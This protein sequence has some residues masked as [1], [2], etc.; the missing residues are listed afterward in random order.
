M[1]RTLKQKVVAAGQQ[2]PVSGTGG[3]AAGEA[4]AR[5]VAMILLWA[6]MGL[7]V[8]RVSV[9]GGLSPFGVGLAAAAAGPGSLLVYIAVSVGYLLSSGTLFP[10]RYI[11]AV[12]AV[13]GIRWSIGAV[14]GLSGNRLLPPVTAFLSTLV[15]GLAMGFVSGLDA[16]TVMAVGCEGIIAGGFAWFC[17][18]TG[19]LAEAPLDRQLTAQEQAAAVITLS[20]L[21]MS[22]AG[23]AFSGISPGRIVAVVAILLMARCGKE[24][25][26]CI[27]GVTLGVALALTDPAHSYL[28]V[29]YAFG[30]LLAGMFARL[31][32]IAAAGAFVVANTIVVMSTGADVAVVAGVYEVAAASVLF[33]VLPSALDRKINGFFV[34]GQELPAV[35]GLRRSVVMRLDFAAKAMDEVAGTVDAVSKKLAQ[36][37][38]PDLGTVYR[39]VSE[40]VC[41]V[42]GKCSFCW[43]TAF[44]DTMSS[45]NDMTATLRKQ[46]HIDREQ[47]VGHLSRNCSRLE[48]V[49]QRVN[50]GYNEYLVR[51]GAFRRLAEIRTV[52]TDQF[53]GMADMLAELSAD[54]DTAE[55]VDEEAAARV[56]EVCEDHGLQAGE[57]VCVIGRGNRMTVEIM[58]ENSRLKIH[59]EEWRQQLGDACGRSFDHPQMTE[60]GGTVR[61]TL[62]E[63]PLFRVT[64]GSAQLNCSQEKL[65]GDAVEV[66]TDSSGRTVAVLSDGMGSGGRA[67]VD[68]AMAAGLTSRLLQAGFGADSVL[69]MVNSALMVKSGDESLATLDIAAVDL[70]TG[71]L[72]SLKAGAAVSLLRSGGRVSRIERSSLPAGILRDISFEKHQ[73]T[74]GDGDILL[75]MSD[76]VLTDGVGWVEEQLQEFDL[77]HSNM[78]SLAETI[79][80]AARRRQQ[81]QRED[82]VSVIALLVQK[83]HR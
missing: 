51:E 75:L 40:D 61:I 83:C 18:M 42:C 14:K 41:R 77:T 49:L 59:E 52:A 30:G 7:L 31:G 63:L 25:G 79:V 66:F 65:C 22:V 26:G 54:F 34:R 32:R 28:A 37:S 72:E 69:R 16:Y 46:G 20:V 60:L 36:I 67:A 19:R 73:D 62:R 6:V 50:H 23:I 21:L 56:R 3:H 5:Q 58:A 29:A 68:G 71:R 76:G 53:A 9:Y 15:A 64:I 80:S 2:E 81:G 57:I 39:Q 27:A 74:L 35:E 48:E 78:Q 4:V 11:G 43:E 38:A 45:F 10:L 82:D 47:V 70:F 12:A 55:R 33:V 17:A 13:A 44:S 1:V 8:P 24:Q